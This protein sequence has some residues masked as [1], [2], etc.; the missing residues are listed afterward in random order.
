MN[1]VELAKKYFEEKYHCS[2]AVLA[3]FVYE[4]GLTE[5]QALKLGGWFDC[6][7]GGRTHIRIL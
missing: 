1:H 5:E 2:Q 7:A 3:A 6:A 4:L